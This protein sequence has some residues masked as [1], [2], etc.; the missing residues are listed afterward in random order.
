[1]TTREKV[2]VGMMCLTIAYGAFE[3]LSS[4]PAN[5]KPSKAT[6]NPIGEIRD[7]VTDISQ[8]L[9]R[10]GTGQ[11]DQYIIGLAAKDWAKDPFIHSIQKVVSD[12][13]PV[14]QK[15]TQVATKATPMEMEYSGYLQVGKVKLAIINGIE[16]VEGDALGIS[17][18]YVRDISAQRVIVGQVNGSNTI[19]LTL[20]EVTN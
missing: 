15:E 17:G 5:K 9:S 16:Y 18:Y 2:I 1:M 3:L 20:K 10:N 14:K 6:Q 13:E 11:D 8:K 7:L 19:R 4:G 12:A